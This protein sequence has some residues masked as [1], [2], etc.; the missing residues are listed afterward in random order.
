MYDASRTINEFLSAAA[1]KQPAPGGGSVTALTG[2]LAASMGEMVL[3][4]SV[5]RKSLAA[6]E[7]ELR[8][9]LAEFT[10]ARGVMLL[11]MAEDQLAYEAVTALRKLPVDAPERQ[12]QYAAT[13]AACIRVPEA[14]AATAA[15]VLELCERLVD[16]VNPYLL[17]DLAVCAELSMATV[18]CGAYN[19]RVNLADVT[20]VME[21]KRLA[22][23]ANGIVTRSVAVV[24]RVIPRIWQSAENP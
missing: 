13:L 3:N 17:S 12:E 22:D 14:M 4:Y 2:A 23:E 6:H 18:R 24:R 7:P 21:R 9:A 10:R 20:D 8:E 1:A 11:L 16:K 19:V 15:A 5:G